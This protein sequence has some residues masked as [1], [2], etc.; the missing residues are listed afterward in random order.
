MLDTWFS[1]GLWP[2]ESSGWPDVETDDYKKFYPTSTLVKGFDIIFF[3]VARMITMG[4][5]FTGVPPFS[6]VYI[7]GL[8]RD[9][10]G[11]KMSKSKGNTIDP[12]LSIEKYG[13]DAVRF[14]L[15]NLCTYGGQDIKLSDEKFEFGRN[16][17]KKVWN[18]SRFVLM[19][20]E[21]KEQNF[22]LL[23]LSIAE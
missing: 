12:V 21:S 3:L 8:I 16:F 22:Y 11:Q 1:S 18:A 14:T 15:A 17:A 23:K 19:N 2:C 6:T 4:L 13:C 10:F 5:E 20:F 9:E 7:H